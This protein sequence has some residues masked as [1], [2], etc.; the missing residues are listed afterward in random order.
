MQISEL[1]NIFLKSTGIVTDSRKIELNSLFFAL[2]GENFNGNLFAKQ[3]IEDGAM[4]S[5][6][7]DKEFAIDDK[8]ILVDNVLTTL[9]KLANYH[10]KQLSF[11]IIGITGTNGKTTTKELVN[12][13]LSKKFKTVATAGN[14]NN[15]I[16][17]PITLLKMSVKDEFGIVEMGA[18]HIGEIDELCKIAEP[19]FG[20]ITN[21]GSAHLEGFGSFEGV[22]KTK[23]EMYRF[24]E[25][26][27]GLI[28]YNSDNSILKNN[29]GTSRTY[30]YGT[31]SDVNVKGEVIDSNPLLR[32]KFIYHENEITVNTN[33]FGSYNFE[34]NMAAVCIGQYFGIEV[35]DIKNAIENYFPQN[36]RSQIKKTD[37]NTLFLDMYNANPTSMAASIENFAELNVNSKVLII[38]GMRELGEVSFDEHFKIVKLI[39]NNNFEKVFLVGDEFSK[40]QSNKFIIFMTSDDLAKYLSE[41]EI[42][43]STILLKGSRG[44]QL[45]KSIKWL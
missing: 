40:V 6:V 25:K 7:D 16:G 39:E 9:Q 11:P 19:D 26:K 20:L 18:N 33:L 28:F 45:E 5:V 30:C 23:T 29:I 34:N 15:H 4:F 24:L 27:Q 44:I 3:A 13:V 14:L 22:I 35:N 42:N 37:K 2:K 8:F 17:V 36:N 12:C 10:R 1:H 38:G 21:I 31:S 43:N 32:F 41:N